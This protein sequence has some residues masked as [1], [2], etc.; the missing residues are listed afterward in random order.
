MLIHVVYSYK[1][2]AE[3]QSNAKKINRVCIYDQYIVFMA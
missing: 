2:Q 3:R 1:R